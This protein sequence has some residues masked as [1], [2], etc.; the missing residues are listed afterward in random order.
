MITDDSEYHKVEGKS[1]KKFIIDE[2]KYHCYLNNPTFNPYCDCI[3]PDPDN[4][5]AT[6][7]GR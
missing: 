5:S 6:H 2:R 4:T 7:C 1:A 3:V